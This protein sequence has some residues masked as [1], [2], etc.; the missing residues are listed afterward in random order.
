[1]VSLRAVRRWLAASNRLARNA[2]CEVSALRN[3]VQAFQTAFTLV[4]AYYA[5]NTF[6][7]A[8][9]LRRG[10]HL[11][12][13]TDIQPLWP[14]EWVSQIDIRLAVWLIVGLNFTGALLALCWPTKRWCRVLAVV[15]FLQYLALEN[16]FGKIN[17]ASHAWFWT[18]FF[19]AGLPDG[20]RRQL[21][22]SR[23]G[24]QR[25]LSWFWGAQFTILLFYTMSGIIK[26]A[27]VPV[28]L[29][30]GEVCALAPEALPRHIAR[31]LL[32]TNSESL[33][34]AFM[35]KHVWLAWVLFIGMLYIEAAAVL[36]AFRP[37]LHR[38][39]GLALIAFHVGVGLTMSIWFLPP[40][41]LAALLLIQSPFAPRTAFVRKL[42]LSL[43]VVGYILQLKIPGPVDRLRWCSGNHT[44]G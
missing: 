20:C 14:V 21:E 32:V 40:I 30:H 11:A 24:R 43:P 10:V 13:I 2:P 8:R 25:Y 38:L 23:R 35:I 31:R 9:G 6:F 15:G 1:M 5:C 19:F 7:A 34:G 26:L 39:W 27:G 33:L 41:M 4:A 18:G 17:H 36:A 29:Y 3:Q 44:S 28:Q 37:S 16:S 42:L 12:G 22:V